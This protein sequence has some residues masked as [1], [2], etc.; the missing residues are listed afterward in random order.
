MALGWLLVFLSAILFIP[1]GVAVYYNATGSLMNIELMALVGTQVAAFVSGFALLFMARGQAPSRITVKD[2]FNIAA[3]SWIVMGVYCAL[4]YILSGAIASPVDALFESISGL[5]TTGASIVS[6]LDSI[7]RGIMLWRHMTQWLGG[8]GIIVLFVAALPAIGSGSHNLFRA[9]IPGGA[10]FAKVTPRIRQT[11][12]A[13]WKIYLL[14]TTIEALTLFIA[15]MPFYDS[16]CHS[17]TTMSTGGFSPYQGSMADAQNGL[18]QWII[19][20]FMFLAGVN[21]TLHYHAIKGDRQ[22]YWESPEF[23]LYLG[24]CCGASVI[25]TLD[26]LITGQGGYGLGE[27]VTHG[28]F[29]T[30]SMLTTTGFASADFGNWAP[31]IQ[32]ILLVLMFSG[33][34]SGSTSGSMKVVRI[35]ITAKAMAG[36]LRSMVNPREVVTSRLGQNVL[37]EAEMKNTLVFLAVFIVS[38]VTGGLLLT[39]SGLDIITAFSASIAC[40]GNVGPGLGGVGPAMNF[41]GIPAVGK[42]ILMAQM[43]MGRLEL[44]GAIVF[45]GALVRARD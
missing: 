12:R 3:S 17:L 32:A 40:I 38:F 10:N 21:F 39:L 27:A 33:G 44:F 23:R 25:V 6:D 22:A 18:I 42:V 11:A 8:M 36:E 2:G 4:P 19:I 43:I 31:F 16:V 34:C 30:I 45:F 13:L 20:L 26:L 15:G 7:P 9:E 24:I 37:S 14:L 1:D 28:V 41:A 5:T 35:L 29:Q